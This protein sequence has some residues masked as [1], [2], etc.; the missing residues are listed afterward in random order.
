MKHIILIL[1]ILWSMAFALPASAIELTAEEK[2]ILAHVVIDPQAW[3]DHAAQA[4]GIQA[5]KAKID[6]YKADYQAKKDLV[7]YKNRVDSEIAALVEKGK[8]EDQARASLGLP[9]K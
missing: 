1:V 6:K 9:A 4:V 8:T 2:A 3:A 5:V 7:G